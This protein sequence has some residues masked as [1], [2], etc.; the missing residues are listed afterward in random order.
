MGIPIL[1]RRHR[2][3]GTPP[4]PPPPLKKIRKMSVD[5][6]AWISNYTTLLY[7]IVEHIEI[8]EHSA[9]I[10]EKL[11]VEHLFYTIF[12]ATNSA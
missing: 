1:V 2:Y 4:P 5:V 10:A 7:Q 11:L 6:K 9:K 8:K 3:I 12:I